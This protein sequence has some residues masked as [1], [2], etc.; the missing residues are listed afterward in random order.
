MFDEFSREIANTINQ[1]V[2]ME[3][4]LG[5]WDKVIENLGR[6]AFHEVLIEFVEPLATLGLNLPAVIRDRVI[7]AA[8]HLMHQANQALDHASWEDDLPVDRKIKR[9]DLERHDR[10]WEAT[11]DLL[12][13]LNRLASPEDYEAATSN[14]RNKYHHRFPA[15]VGLGMSGLVTRKVDPVTRKASYEIGGADPL[16]IG[17]IRPF[18]REQIARAHAVN[19]AFK[20]LVGGF[21]TAIIAWEA[22]HGL[23]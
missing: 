18:L 19:A 14:F 21:E 8:A 22:K 7:F 23:A 13:A 3:R 16:S 6:E 11:A 1:L 9:D 2:N 10:S 17:A 5:A 4:R 20:E 15:R 12:A